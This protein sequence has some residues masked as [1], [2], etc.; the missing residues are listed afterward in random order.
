MWGWWASSSGGYGLSDV[1]MSTY[2]PINF[3]IPWNYNVAP[4]D[5]K[6]PT[7][8]TTRYEYARVNSFGS[9]HAGGANFAMVDG[10]VRFLK[11]AIAPSVLRALGTRAGSEVLSAD[12][13]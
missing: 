10:S 3:K 5:A 12:S 11:E 7:T 13:Y 6:S 1:A 4:S 2:A 8:F 9:Q